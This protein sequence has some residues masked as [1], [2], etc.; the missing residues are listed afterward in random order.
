M[1]IF[2]KH[3]PFPF[4][5]EAEKVWIVITAML[6]T[7]TLSEKNAS[8]SRAKARHLKKVL[9][10]R[11]SRPGNT[12]LVTNVMGVIHPD[13]APLLLLVLRCISF[14]ADRA[15]CQGGT[16]ILKDEEETLW[17]SEGREITGLTWDGNYLD[18]FSLTI[19]YIYCQNITCNN[20]PVIYAKG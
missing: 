18:F 8:V 6:P 19:N 13:Q 12:T 11:L 14:G 1:L 9:L 15:F 2:L 20:K 10:S 17:G 5:S 16:P 7:P 3:S 4:S